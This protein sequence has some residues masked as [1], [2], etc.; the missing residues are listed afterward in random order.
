MSL[1]N[2]IV[3]DHGLPGRA[4]AASPE[5]TRVLLVDPEAR[6]ASELA[7]ALAEMQ[8]AGRFHI[9]PEPDLAAARQR[10]SAGEVDVA[11]LALP[12]PGERGVLPLPEL[13]A[14]AP[15]V[16]IVVLADSDNEPLAIKAVQL[17]AADYLLA[18]QLYGTLVARCLL[19]AV[20]SERVRA[21]L[22]RHQ[23]EWLPLVAPDRA[24][25]AHAAPLRIAMPDRFEALARDYRQLL[26]QAVE[27]LARRTDLQLDRRARDLA[28]RVGEL[29]AGA[30]DVVEIH[31]HAI[32]ASQNEHGPLR[33]KL[34]V[35]EGR[36]RL[37]EL[38]GHLTN[39]YRDLSLAGQRHSPR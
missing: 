35:A 11:V 39:Y 28:C 7:A 27:Q 15:Q 21:Q 37:L 29:R 23:E 18:G 5:P 20:Q 9:A 34:Y 17:G 4:D 32:D 22:A 31:A 26:D 2:P 14:A 25:A 19:H 6:H 1:D 36:V 12:F 13:C 3:A 16:P 24:T 8:D 33:M 38:M 10:L 30:R